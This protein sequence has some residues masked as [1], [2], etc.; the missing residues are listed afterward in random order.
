MF[1]IASLSKW[2][3]MRI[4]SYENEFD[5]HENEPAGDSPMN[6]FALRFVLTKKQKTTRKW[7]TG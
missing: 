4:L 5:W 7:P 2:V 3:F 6:G 1:P